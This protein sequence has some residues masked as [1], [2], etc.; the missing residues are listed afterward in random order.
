MKKIAILIAVEQ[1]LN[2]A[3]GDVAY[4]RNDAEEFSR[5]L[6]LHGFDNADQL[7]LIDSQ[8]TKGV[9]ESKVQR[10]ISRLEHDD[11]LYLYYA[12]HGFSKS[13]QNFITCH[14][15]QDSD[16]EGT[17]VALEPLFRALR[18]SDCEKVALF[19]DCCESGIDA[20]AGM[21]GIYDNLKEYELEDFL[22]NA[23]H[24]ICFAACRSDESSFSSDTLK[25]GIWTYH[26]IEAFKGDASL[27]LEKGFLV[28]SSLQNYLK[29]EVPRTVRTTYTS[30]REQT[31]WMYGASS[32]DFPLADLREILRKRQ[33][34]ANQGNN[35]TTDVSFVSK[36]HGSVKSLSGWKR[37]HRVPDYVN[38]TSESFIVGISAGDLKDELDSVYDSL[39]KEFGF[40]RRDLNASE[41]EDGTGTIITPYFNYSVSV[42]LNPDDL[43][44][45]IWH[46]TV[47]GITAPGHVE[48][49]A[50]GAVFDKVF[51]TLEFSLPKRVNI[52][53]LIDAIEA[54][55]I[56]D[57]EIHYDRGFTSCQLQIDGADTTVTVTSHAL[58][59]VHQQPEATK[60][61]IQSFD[62]VKSLVYKH[63]VPLISFTPSKVR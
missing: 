8:A 28:S 23:S 37:T 26:L 50:F 21:R 7:I 29:A 10:A 61:L 3:I 48:S 55:K 46:R 19:L 51:D 1:Y 44:E 6:E 25:H 59:I 43:A 15:T 53:D 54:A 33:E 17:S 30:S 2:P 11:I 41:P 22:D 38:G 5:A 14:D 45:V 9:I 52:E 20:T 34:A 32:G 31:P 47:D 49:D 16:W 13:G 27:A 63:N 12:G 62:E 60:R 42:A 40:T 35:L 18:S 24:C 36:E 56:P 57:L 4:A 58:S 39:R